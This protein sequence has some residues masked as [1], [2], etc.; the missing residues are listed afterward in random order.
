MFVENE[1]VSYRGS[2]GI[3]AFIDTKYVVIEITPVEGRNAPRIV[4]YRSDYENII[5]Q[6]DYLSK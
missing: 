5:R 1:P 2:S 6:D 4:V 3:I